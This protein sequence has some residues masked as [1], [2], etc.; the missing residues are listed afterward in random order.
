[1]RSKSFETDKLASAMLL[2]RAAVETAA[3][4]WYLC[5]KI[6]AAA[7]S[8]VVADIGDYMMRLMMGSK[9]DLTVR[10]AINALTFVDRVDKDISGFRHQYDSLSEFAHPN[11][12][13]TALLYSKPD[14]SNLRTDLGAT[15]RSENSKEIGVANLSVALMFFER[16]YNRIDDLMPGFITL[17]ESQL[18]GQR[19]LSQ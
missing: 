18:N 3:A 13:G 12:A 16:S 11:W 2:T 19:P 5:A 15:L 17:C 8:G 10:E 14:P 4:L 6:E 7:Q 1:M 9:T